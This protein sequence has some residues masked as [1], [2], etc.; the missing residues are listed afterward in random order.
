MKLDVHLPDLNDGSH[1]GVTFPDGS[2]IYNCKNE[3]TKHTC[4]LEFNS[5]KPISKTLFMTILETSSGIRLEFY[6]PTCF[7]E[8]ILTYIGVIHYQFFACHSISFSNSILYNITRIH[9]MS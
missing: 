1:C 5:L 7:I 3:L 8:V 2:Q 9:Q 6:I 4:V